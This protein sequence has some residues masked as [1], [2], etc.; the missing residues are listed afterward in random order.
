MSIFRSR[1]NMDTDGFRTRL[2]RKQKEKSNFAAMLDRMDWYDI[3]QHSD[4]RDKNRVKKFKMNYGLMEGVLDVKM[5]DDPLCFKVGPEEVSFDYQNVSHYPLISQVAKTIIGEESSRPFNPMIKDNTPDFQ[6]YFKKESS[7]RVEM[8]LQS[9]LNKKKQEL[10]L[11][12]LKSSGVEDPYSLSPEDQ[13]AIQQE[14]QFQLE[15][16]SPENIIDY[17]K[18]DFQTPTA[19]QAQKMLD[20]LREYHNIKFKNTLGFKH[21]VCTA[22]EYYFQGERNGQLVFE[23]VPPIY[24][25]WGGSLGVEWSQHGTWAKRENW[26][27]YQDVT[28]RHA[29]HLSERDLKDLDFYHEPFGGFSGKDIFDTPYHRKVQYEYGRRPDLQAKFGDINIKTKEGQR[30]MLEMY[31][32]I[33]TPDLFAHKDAGNKVIG[34][35]IF[36]IREAHITWRDKRI[37][38]KVKRPINGE[39]KTFYLDEHYEERPEDYEVQKIWVDEVWEGYKL[40]TYEA[41]YVNVRPVPYQYK[42]LDNPYGVDLPYYGKKYNSNNGVSPNVSLI[43]LGKT[44]NKD[45]DITMSGLKHDLATNHGKK[46]LITLNAKP[47][48][49]KMQEWLDLIRNS[50]FIPVDF[51]KKGL[52]QLDFQFSKEVDLSKMSDIAGKINLL[53]VFRD[54]VAWSMYFNNARLG[55]QGQ[56]ANTTNIQSNQQ[57]SY[58]QT[59]LFFEQHRL[60]MEKALQAFLNYARFYY[61]DNLDKA[62]V[63]LDDVSLAELATG[64]YTA[65]SEMGISLSNSPAEMQKLSVLKQQALTLI[66]NGSRPE[67]VLKM[68]L[69]DSETEVQELIRKESRDIE[70]RRQEELKIQQ[71]QFNAGLQQ[72]MQA[73]DK[74]LQNEYKMHREK[75]DTSTQNTL[76]DSQKFANQQDIDQN[77]QNDLLTG[78]LAELEAKL[79]MHDDVMALEREKL[80]LKE[81]LEQES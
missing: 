43:D 67:S 6:T 31:S 30:R 8:H 77:G 60:I 61:K 75:L 3:G 32:E 78:K 64:P 62:K 37:L 72:K 41:K 59:A 26:L 44:F 12:I 24:F 29:E 55:S 35:D 15:K 40:G 7:E 66:Q 46:L 34:N 49:Y 56:Y 5:Y 25:N 28:Q 53:Q 65:F 2:T 36:G 45:F 1:H 76:I 39:L 21:A 68:I 69:A 58:H 10:T 20:Y 9:L 18:Y 54:G 52:S 22:E 47:D 81:K 13:M 73:D 51:S 11:N 57:A 27:T 38:K 42:S 23:E 79:K 71:D 16:N 48:E 63:F 14:V 74:K 4:F 70:Q 33:Y 80:Q 50:P 19:K 17:M